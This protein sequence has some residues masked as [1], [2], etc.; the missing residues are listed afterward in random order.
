MFKTMLVM[1]ALS[2]TATAHAGGWELSLTVEP[3]VRGETAH[4]RLYPYD[5]DLTGSQLYFGVGTSLTGTPICP[6]VMTNCLGLTGPVTLLHSEVA[7]APNGPVVPISP[8]AG[9][10]ATEAYFEAVAFAPVGEM[11][12]GALAQRIYDRSEV[13][14]IRVE[15]T[16]IPTDAVNFPFFDIEE[17][18]PGRIG[19]VDREFTAGETSWTYE[20]FAPIGQV[21]LFRTWNMRPT[22]ASPGATIT[23]TDLDAGVVTLTHHVDGVNGTDVVGAGCVSA[24]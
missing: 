6:P 11:V 3:I 1:A 5:V 17:N 22:A 2:A 12:S 8:P 23:V 10:A 16:D 14:R 19:W 7:S 20:V 15:I 4:M 18:V 24:N 21:A 13:C 9:I